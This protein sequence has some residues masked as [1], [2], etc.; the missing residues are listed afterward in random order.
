[1]LSNE[2]E[3]LYRNA[4]IAID[5][6]NTKKIELLNKMNHDIRTPLNAIISFSNMLLKTEEIDR[7][8][9]YANKINISSN[10]LLNLLNDILEIGKMESGKLIIK[11]EDFSIKELLEEVVLK[12][13]YINID[14]SI[15]VKIDNNIYY[16]HY[17][18][19]RKIEQVL[20]NIISN[21][22][23]YTD[24][25]GKIF[26][27]IKVVKNTDK[28]QL[29]EFD[30]SDNGIG[31]SEETIKS[32][33]KPYSRGNVE[34]IQG[35]GLGMSIV[36]EIVDLLGGEIY[37]SS[38]QNIGTQIKVI[39]QIEKS[40]YIDINNLNLLVAEDNYFNREIINEIF[41]E[42]NVK[43]DIVKNGLEA[44]EKYLL[45]PNYDLIFMDLE[46]PILN[47]FE[48]TKKIRNIDKS[49]PIIAMSA[50][51]FQSEIEKALKYTMNDY[52]VKPIEINKL[53]RILFNFNKK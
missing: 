20:M 5:K 48:A 3:E 36:K 7:I 25:Y 10:Y 26:I 30:V 33:F 11:K 32:I 16:K 43:Y 41:K 52:M 45:N 19:K 53:K 23:K 4:L 29:I 31:M 9:D 14:K 37:I 38:E 28:S 6:I 15:N 27:D 50:N 35:T 40:E 8:K 18:D 34:N 1:M 39:F 24:K 51:S 47:G 44:Y 12:L 17:G 46:M 21:S 42:L 13:K 22:V 49:V 2:K